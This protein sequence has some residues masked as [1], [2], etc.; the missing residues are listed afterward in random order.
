[1]KFFNVSFGRTLPL[2]TIAAVVIATALSPTA[3]AQGSTFKRPKIAKSGPYVDSDIL[4]SSG[5]HTVVPR[6]AVLVV[7]QTHAKRKVAKPT[8]VFTIWPKFLR[9]NYGWIHKYEVTLDQASGK[10]PISDEK[11]ES[12]KSMGKVVVAVYK[13]NPISVLPAKPKP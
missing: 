6:G 5:F 10:T 4:A 7:P 13:N 11:M 3:S 1:M 12:L 2:L 9:K 8:G